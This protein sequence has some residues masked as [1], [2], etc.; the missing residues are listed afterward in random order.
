MI[1]KLAPK[2]VIYLHVFTM[3]ICNNNVEIILKYFLLRK[4][5]Y[6]YPFLLAVFSDW[7]LLFYSLKPTTI[8]K[9]A[10]RSAILPNEIYENI[11]KYNE[12]N[13]LKGNVKEYMHFAYNFC[14]LTFHDTI[15]NFMRC[16]FVCLFQITLKSLIFPFS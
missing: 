8:M 1:R 5:Y 2:N 15:K 10:E 11:N 14:I 6:Y 3:K 12:W 4:G 16:I 7:Y 13:I 9:S